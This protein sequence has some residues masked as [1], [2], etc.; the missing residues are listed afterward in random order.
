MKEMNDPDVSIDKLL[1]FFNISH[2]MVRWNADD[3]E[4]E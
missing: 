4:F 3:Q 1:D 2:D